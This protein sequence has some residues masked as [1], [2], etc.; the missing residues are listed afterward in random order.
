MERSVQS[1]L[2]KIAKAYDLTVEEY[3][4]DI[5]PMDKVPARFRDSA[6]VKQ[7]LKMSSGNDGRRAIRFF[8]QPRKGMRFL[9]V[10][11]S[12]DLF[13][14]DHGRWAST[15]YGVD[16]SSA[17]VKA[18]RN[19]AKSRGIR[20][21]GLEVADMATMPFDDGFFDIAAVIGV[22]EYWNLS[23]CRRALKELHRVLKPKARV[24]LDLPNLKHP[25]VVIMRKLEAYLGRPHATV[26]RDAFERMLLRNFSIDRIDDAGAMTV[27][28]LRAKHCAPLHNKNI[29]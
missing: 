23:Y 1:R 9:D 25:D 19:V 24:V 16:I 27:Y 18:M 28:F 15:Y 21:G 14:Y 13:N 7:F 3:F 6:A 10:G 12:A 20:I 26:D 4:N 17:L 2:K 29:E 11:S 22:L 8:L 5:D